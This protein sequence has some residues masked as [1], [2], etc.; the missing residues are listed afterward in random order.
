[1]NQPYT[2]YDKGLWALIITIL[3][4]LAYTLT[5]RGDDTGLHATINRIS[6]THTDELKVMQDQIQKL[7]DEGFEYSWTEPRDERGFVW[8]KYGP[9]PWIRL[10]A[11][12]SEDESK[13]IKK[14]LKI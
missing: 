12:L 8:V 13:Q 11:L 4:W 9:M 7:A 5:S 14:L 10:H 1:M 6:F 2:A 3:I